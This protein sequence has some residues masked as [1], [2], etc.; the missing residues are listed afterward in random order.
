VNFA[1]IGEDNTLWFYYAPDNEIVFREELV[2]YPLSAYSAPAMILQ[3]NDVDI[4]F[5]GQD[6]EL[7]FDWAVN[8]SSTWNPETIEGAGTA[9][10][11]LR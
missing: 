4:T 3:G 5:Q 8:G 9:C 11:A 7:D 10:S 6:N 2:S 1:A